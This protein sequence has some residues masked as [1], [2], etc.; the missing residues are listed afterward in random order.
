MRISDW[1]SDVCSSD[2]EKAIRAI[3]DAVTRQGVDILA[4]GWHS[5]VAMA[6]MDATAPMDIVMIGHGG[7]SQY[8]CEKINNDQEKYAHWFRSEERRVGKECVS[9]CRYSWSR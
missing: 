1:S 3:G 5:S 4:S 8:I 6:A 7:E 9:T 2:L